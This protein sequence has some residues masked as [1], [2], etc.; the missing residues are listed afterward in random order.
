MKHFRPIILLSLLTLSSL[1]QEKYIKWQDLKINGLS[2]SATKNDIIKQFGQPRKVFEPNYECGFLSTDWQGRKFYSLLYPSVL[3]TGN[4]T[5]NY[6][7]EHIY[8]SHKSGI[9]VTYEGITLSAGTSIKTFE[10][11][12]KAKVVN[13]EIELYFPGAD[14][15][16]IV[17]FKKG[18]LYRIEYWSPC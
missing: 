4:T 13:N 8:F 1:A 2:F 16:L 12:L 7:L 6:Q 14:D 3:F 17:T 10:A 5:D 15:K 18:L 9:K 11:I